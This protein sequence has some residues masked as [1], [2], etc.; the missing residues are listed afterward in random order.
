MATLNGEI[1]GKSDGQLW[2]SRDWNRLVEVVDGLQE[3]LFGENGLAQRVELLGAGVDDLREELARIDGRVQDLA[4]RF[5]R[6]TLASSRNRYAL[7]E[8]AEVTARLTDLDGRPLPPEALATATVDFVST[9]GSLLPAAGFASRLGTDGRS[10]SVRVNAQGEARVRL[11]PE[12]AEGLPEQADVEVAD[13]L[14]TVLGAGVSVGEILLEAA[15]PRQALDR[16]AFAAITAE[17]ERPQA[18]LFRSY[19]DSYF[20]VRANRPDG[21]VGPIVV[22]PPVVGWREERATVL[23]FARDDDDPL[24]ADP[25]RAFSSLTVTF[26][27]WVRHW[28]VDH[29]LPG[30]REAVPGIRERLGGDLTLDPTTTMENFRRRFAAEVRPDGVLGRQR[31]L[32]ALD[33]AFETLRV[34]EQA[35]GFLSGLRDSVRNAVGIQR[36][37][38]NARFA[39]PGADREEVAFRVFTRAEERGSRGVDQ[40]GGRLDG[41]ADL[42]DQERDR[43]AVRIAAVEAAAAEGRSAAERARESVEALAATRLP[44]LERRLTER[45]G[46]LRDIERT[47]GVLSGR[48]NVDT[49]GGVVGGPAGPLGGGGVLSPR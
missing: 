45:A 31:D 37:L 25:G 2:K 48:L 6:L 49:R 17:Y 42:F 40:L 8:L 29:Y 10:L 28:I 41:L 33:G 3:G 9:W 12:H 43:T 11:R 24:T 27:D 13:A 38:D 39:T 19:A 21:L 44:E 4:G 22:A 30:F 23:A 18:G 5:R 20:L 35:P 15:T 16:G 34:G 36:T 7:G 1:G 14:T 47:L 46:E 26:V 32:L